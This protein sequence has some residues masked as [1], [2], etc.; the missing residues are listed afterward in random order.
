MSLNKNNKV[1]LNSIFDKYSKTLTELI[2][3]VSDEIKNEEEK[4][5][6][7]QIKRIIRLCPQEERLIQTK[8]TLWELRNYI[9][10]RDH[11]GL[12]NID[13]NDFI[14]KNNNVEEKEFIL[15]IID[16]IKSRYDEIKE[17]RKNNYWTTLTILLQCIIEYKQIIGEYS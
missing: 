8:E 11:I 15:S 5:H 4:T 16:I 17:E 7:D 13:P 14:N 1:K 12:K 6:L 10:T 9:L 2:K 3:N